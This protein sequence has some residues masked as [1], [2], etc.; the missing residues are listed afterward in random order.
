MATGRPRVYQ[1]VLTDE[2]RE[3]LDGITRRGQALARDIQRANILLLADAGH[4][5]SDVA[6]EL[7]TSRV[8][9]NRVAKRFC[10][11]GLAA[12]IHDRARCGRESKL[13]ST[14]TAALVTLA[15][16]DP[17][18]GRQRWTLRLLSDRLVALEV[19]DCIS[20]ET[21]RQEL[22]KTSSSPGR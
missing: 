5:H 3:E 19:V 11:E 20:H 17:P 9:V 4:S 22:K 18:Q 13:D 12:A 1:V 14:Q 2:Q 10:E 8:R 6:R 21:V 15:C 7:R 16:S